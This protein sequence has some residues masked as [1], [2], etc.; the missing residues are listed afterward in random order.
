[1]VGLSVLQIFFIEKSCLPRILFIIYLCIIKYCNPF[2][3]IIF[4][5]GQGSG[6]RSWSDDQSRKVKTGWWLKISCHQGLALF[7]YQNWSIFFKGVHVESLRQG[8]FLYCSVMIRN[9][10]WDLKVHPYNY[11][12]N[13]KT[14]LTTRCWNLKSTISEVPR[15]ILL[16][17]SSRQLLWHRKAILDVAFFTIGLL[18]FCYHSHT[19]HVDC[20]YCIPQ[21]NTIYVNG[22][23]L[24]EKILQEEFTKF[25]EVTC[26]S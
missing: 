10:I 9:K 20:L 7:L 25:G 16:L 2:S 4:N 21:G 12:Y 26:N 22:Y 1:M 23:G 13:Y 3:W 19:L 5:L 24:T 8:S 14:V 15:S 6:R 18:L 17:N 11:V